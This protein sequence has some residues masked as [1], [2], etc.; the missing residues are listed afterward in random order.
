MGLFQS[1]FKI[2][3]LSYIRL[4]HSEV[5]FYFKNAFA[6]SFLYVFLYVFYAN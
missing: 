2:A 1:K 4:F 3:E 6:W 5:F